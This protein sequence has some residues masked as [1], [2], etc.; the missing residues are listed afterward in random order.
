ME[1]KTIID[2][3]LA[4]PFKVLNKREIDIK[5]FIFTLSLDNG[6]CSPSTALRILKYGIEKGLLKV[7]ESKVKAIFDFNKYKIP[8]NFSISKNDIEKYKL[9]EATWNEF[10]IYDTTTK[11][12]NKKSE[13]K[14]ARANKE[15]N[16]VGLKTTKEE[17]RTNNEEVKKENKKR[18]KRKRDAGINALSDYF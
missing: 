8:V 9:P 6:V 17:K 15:E 1:E 7:N 14:E 3:V 10:N 12:I 11:V 13:L 16:K 4:Y 5:K 18:K 2:L